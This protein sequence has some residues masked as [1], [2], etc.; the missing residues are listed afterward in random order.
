MEAATNGWSVDAFSGLLCE[1][2]AVLSAHQKSG[3]AAA[4]P[5]ALEDACQKKKQGHAAK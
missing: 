5:A 1:L 4:M 2:Y 3:D